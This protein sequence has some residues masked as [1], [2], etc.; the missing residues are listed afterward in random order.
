MKTKND[1]SR[2]LTNSRVNHSQ[3]LGCNTTEHDIRNQAPE[4]MWLICLLNSRFLNSCS[5]VTTQSS[6]QYQKDFVSSN[7]DATKT[8]Q[9]LTISSCRLILA[10]DTLNVL[11][12]QQSIKLDF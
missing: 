11:K 5:K 1:T 3:I 12:A 2:Q 4:Q 7:A 8:M 10:I 6:S 9:L